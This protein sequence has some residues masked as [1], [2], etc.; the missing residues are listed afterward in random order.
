MRARASDGI[1]ANGRESIVNRLLEG[2]ISPGS[3]LVPF[4]LN[5]F[6]VIVK[7]YNNLYLRLV[8]AI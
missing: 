8:N 4:S 5:F 6:L 2:S 3:K 7:K 1:R